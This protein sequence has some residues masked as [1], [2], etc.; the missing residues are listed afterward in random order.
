MT[1]S[2]GL[3]IG[4]ANLVAAR[5]GR[6]ALPRRSVL[7]L[8]DGRASEVGVA[9]ERPDT[10]ETGLT[11]R[12]FVQRVGDPVPLVGP[13]GS[14]HRGER[15][16]AEALDALARSVGYGAP[17]AVAVPAHW[18]PGPV[19]AL[20]AALATKPGLARDGTPP[21]LVS[22]SAA[23]TAALFADPGLPTHGVIALC[24][25][26]ADG[27]SITLVDAAS[28]FAP[29]AETV[30]Y[31]DFSGEQIDQAIIDHVL[32]TIRS[33]TDPAGTAA[34]GS[35][36][37]LRD[38]CRSAKERLSSDDAA[39]IAVEL[40][41]FAGDVPLTRAELDDLIAT[42]LAGFLATATETFTRNGISR[43]NL[44]AVATV[45]GGA[46]IPLVAAQLAERLQ[47]PIV[48]RPQPELSAAIG[49]RVLAGQ[50]PR[51]DT[52]TAQEAAAPTGL[53]PAADTATSLA[54][55]PWA[56][57]ET[58]AE[59]TGV[60]ANSDT[61]PALAWSLEDTGPD[62]PVPYSGDDYSVGEYWGSGDDKG[63]TAADEYAEPVPLAWYQQPIV[64][65][66]LAAALALAA[67]VGLI[68]TLTN[69]GDPTEHH[70]RF[71]HKHD[72]RAPT[73]V[74]VTAPNGETS[75]S[76][77]PPPDTPE[78]DTTESET[79]DSD[80]STKSTTTEATTTTKA[81]TTTQ[82]P[83]SSTKPPTHTSAATTSKAPP[84]T[85]DSH[86]NGAASTTP[87]TMTPSPPA[88]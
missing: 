11:I 40:P 18:G 81:P 26:G 24:D 3:S 88:G 41:G 73:V 64:L 58:A 38:R 65:F 31:N 5:A 34:V 46:A 84:V 79:T 37:R 47:V 15:L 20:R 25:F 86:R 21:P 62:E 67:L 68:Y 83:S 29:V 56:A 61:V 60:G 52:K 7:T 22:D 69:T 45:G 59:W 77:I 76:T 53:S 42:P 57:G 30:R 2:L 4:T 55:A 23:A 39:V 82:E 48:T 70:I 33:D 1:D 44:T 51:A 80:T 78:P 28:N 13:D 63:G 10:G 32:A 54:P 74:T 49:A 72:D 43:D 35:L 14:A 66:G 85:S 17:V 12:G 6:Q 36:T 27:S 75:L 71:P 50:G 9:G 16:L 87:A 8:F 19:T